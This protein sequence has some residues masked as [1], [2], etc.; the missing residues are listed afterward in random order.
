MNAGGDQN[1]RVCGLVVLNEFNAFVYFCKICQREFESG[2]DFEAHI[3]SS[4]QD[5]NGAAFGWPANDLSIASANDQPQ[6]EIFKLKMDHFAELFDWLS[7]GDLAALGQ[8]C[9]RMQR[10]VGYHIKTNYAATTFESTK[11]GIIYKPT[12]DEVPIEL[13]EMSSFMTRLAIE[14][15]EFEDLQDEWV[16]KNAIPH[17]KADQFKSL[18]EIQLIKPEITEAIPFRIQDILRQVEIVKLKF[19]ENKHVDFYESFLQFCPNLKKLSIHG[20]GMETIVG[21]DDSWLRRKYP[22]LEHLELLLACH[23]DQRVPELPIFFEQNPQIKSFATTIGTIFWH[24]HFFVNCQLN[25]E[26]LS[27]EFGEFNVSLETESTKTSRDLLNQLH[28]HGL[29]KQLHVYFSYQNDFSQKD[30]TQL[31]SFNGLTKLFIAHM[32][33]NVIDLTPL[34]FLKQLCVD[35]TIFILDMDNLAKSLKNLEHFQITRADVDDIIPFIHHSPKLNTIVVLYL[36]KDGLNNFNIQNL[37]KERS[38]L[39]NARK[40]TLYVEESVYLAKKSA[41]NNTNCNFIEIK[42]GASYEALNHCFDYEVVYT[43]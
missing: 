5:D 40:V 10:Y 19:P 9:K 2:L 42:R 31:R 39:A 33:Q 36:D 37:N 4:H 27:I 15:K 25:L 34:I 38:K 24:R 29:F 3:R 22:S 12:D 43:F 23:S 17:M 7:L 35:D 16:M 6:A 32:D 26:V 20:W 41:Y 28:E 21:V 14:I 1:N 8:T 30:V 18:K 13:G 11:N